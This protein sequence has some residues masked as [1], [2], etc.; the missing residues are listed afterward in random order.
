M[1]RVERKTCN[2]REREKES[3]WERATGMRREERV[4]EIKKSQ[5]LRDLQKE[6]YLERK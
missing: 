6:K 1:K 3:F 4:L 5:R 2:D